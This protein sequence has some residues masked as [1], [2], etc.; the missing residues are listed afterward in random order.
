MDEKQRAQEVAKIANAMYG[1]GEDVE[2]IHYEE[3]WVLYSEGGET[4][5]TLD[6]PDVQREIDRAQM[7]YWVEPVN[8]ALLAVYA[9]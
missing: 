6:W 9:R 5:W 2:V 4:D 8:S 3:R 7:P 1:K